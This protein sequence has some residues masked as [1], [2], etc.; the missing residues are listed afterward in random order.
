M[1]RLKETLTRG[2]NQF[3]FGPLPGSIADGQVDY[4]CHI[5]AAVQI[6]QVE[7]SEPDIDDKGEDEEE[8]A[9][10][11]SIWVEVDFE[12]VVWFICQRRADS[13]YQLKVSVMF[14]VIIIVA[15]VGWFSIC[16]GYTELA[17][18][19]QRVPKPI[20]V[21]VQVGYIS[22]N[23]TTIMFNLVSV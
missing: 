7:A 11:K 18:L 14:V 12:A 21:K 4:E 9:D 16:E 8:D 22:P 15:A 3:K 19:P 6:F 5:N 10:A 2:E 20:F 13:K 1:I 17:I 23:Q